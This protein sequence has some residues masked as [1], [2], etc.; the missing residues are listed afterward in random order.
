MGP[1][2]G[3]TALFC[4]SPGCPPATGGT[5]YFDDL[6]AVVRRCPHGV[7][8]RAGCLSGGRCRP[9]H[10]GAGAFVIVQPCDAGRQ[11]RG[12]A[13]VAGPL[14][15]P[16]DVDDLCGW[17]CDGLGVGAPLPTH[18]LAMDGPTPRDLYR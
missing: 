6:R 18:L 11:P 9:S 1:P 8:V 10:G 3:F 7:L 5:D 17:L 2:V 4:G 13:L 16:A 14:H 15:E 12:Q